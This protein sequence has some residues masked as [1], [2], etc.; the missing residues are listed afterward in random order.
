MNG[1]RRLSAKLQ[2]PEFIAWLLVAATCDPHVARWFWRAGTK[3]WQTPFSRVLLLAFR[4][5]VGD[6]IDGLL[7]ATS[8]E[9]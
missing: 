4:R 1:K 3:H 9:S 6:L 5:V 2:I 7:Y 8:G